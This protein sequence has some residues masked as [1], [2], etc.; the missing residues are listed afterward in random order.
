[1]PAESTTFSPLPPI[2]VAV[3]DDDVAFLHEFIAAIETTP[4]IELVNTA[5]TLAQAMRFLDGPAADVLLVDLGL[6]DGSGITAIRKAREHWPTCPIMVSTAFADELH[7]IQSIEA[8]A[9][10]YLLKDSSAQKLAEDIR[11]LHAGGSPIS[12]LIARQ[13]LL[14]FH[15]GAN[16]SPPLPSKDFTNAPPPLSTR[17]QEVL[18][19]ITKGFTYDEIGGLLK[20]SRN[21]VMTF[22]RRIYAKLEVKSKAEAI[23]EANQRRLLGN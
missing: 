5:N 4:D 11:S 10:G 17:E 1:M 12:P 9:S 13:V 18:G 3:V 21:T 23:H 15:R 6:P 7:V 16:A 14:R 20:I 19:L 2:R 8:G 22:V